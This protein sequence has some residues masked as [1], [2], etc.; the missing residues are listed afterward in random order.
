[1][2]LAYRAWTRHLFF[3]GVHLFMCWEWVIMTTTTTNHFP[4]SKA[5]AAAATSSA[6]LAFV[7]VSLGLV[8]C[9][10]R[11]NNHDDNTLFQCLFVVSA[12]CLSLLHHETPQLMLASVMGLIFLTIPS[13][14]WLSVSDDFTHTVSLL[15]TVWNGDTGA[16]IAGRVFAKSN[17]RKWHRRRPW[18]RP[19]W[20]IKVSPAKS[21]EGLVGALVFGTATYMSLPT[22]WT[23]IHYW[24]LA[25]GEESNKSMSM[26]ADSGDTVLSSSFSSFWHRLSIGMILALL[27]D[28]F[29]SSIKR[30]FN[31]KDSGKLLPGHGGVLDRFDSSLIAVLFYDYYLLRKK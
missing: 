1:M 21:I 17:I 4:P 24:N 23:W 8:N 18:P 14:A 26:T 11:N 3:Q 12:A 13:R 20:L 16:L 30:T 27:G 5:A 25:P 6:R 31:V 2:L 15:L 22:F 7:I 10:V 29:E 28:L 9:P 19:Q